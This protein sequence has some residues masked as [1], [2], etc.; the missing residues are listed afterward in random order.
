M[1]SAMSLISAAAKRKTQRFLR[2]LFVTVFSDADR[3][4][5]ISDPDGDANETYT[6]SKVQKTKRFGIEQFTTPPSTRPIPIL[7]VGPGDAAS[8]TTISFGDSYIEDS[9]LI[10]PSPL[11]SAGSIVESP[12]HVQT[13]VPCDTP[14]GWRRQRQPDNLLGVQCRQTQKDHWSGV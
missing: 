5:H 12:S 3:Y 2:K 10:T 8:S 6:S 1:D 13:S 14:S 7:Q 9:S 4:G 11:Q